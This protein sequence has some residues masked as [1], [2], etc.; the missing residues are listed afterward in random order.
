MK[1][2]ARL[3]QAVPAL[4][5]ALDE[6]TAHPRKAEDTGKAIRTG[7]HLAQRTVNTFSGSHQWSMPL[8]ASTLF[9]NKSIISSEIFR[10]VFPHANV[11]YI[12]ALYSSDSNLNNN[13]SKTISNENDTNEYAHSC[14]DAVMAAFSKDDEHNETCGG[15]NSYKT[16]EG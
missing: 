10:Y 9:G 13:S 15:T 16:P 11:S 3:K 12:D 8:M 5:V 4:L 7:K 1:E 14:L 6:I 2:R